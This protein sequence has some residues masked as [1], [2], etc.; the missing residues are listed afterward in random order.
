MWR[1]GL[2]LVSEN[3]VAVVVF[4][5]QEL[6]RNDI[7]EP[8][9]SS[10]QYQ[11]QQ[12]SL[13]QELAEVIITFL[14]ILKSKMNTNQFNICKKSIV[15]TNQMISGEKC[16]I[17]LVVATSEEL[18]AQTKTILHDESYFGLLEKQVYP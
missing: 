12:V 7:I 18:E 9:K 1:L 6:I 3:R 2:E 10:L 17:P 5:S 15:L 4:P 13:I 8:L 16:V 14:I 11:M